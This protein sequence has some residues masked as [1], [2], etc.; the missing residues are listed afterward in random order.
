ME[1]LARMVA[2]S[3]ARHGCDTSIDHRRLNWSPWFRCELNVDLLLVPS[4]AGIF[5]LAEE[6]I[7]GVKSESVATSPNTDISAATNSAGTTSSS[8]AVNA[9]ASFGIS[10]HQP[11]NV[12]AHLAGSGKMQAGHDHSRRLLAVFEIAETNDL[13]AALLRL[14]APGSALRDRLRSGRCFARFTPVADGAQRHAAATS[15]REWLVSAAASSP[16]NREAGT[17]PVGRTPA[18]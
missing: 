4:A 2:A 9:C 17:L 10:V 5:A 16:S 11:G 1:E 7:P 3:M 6:V 8:Q 13:G 14:F 12:S 15:L 18:A